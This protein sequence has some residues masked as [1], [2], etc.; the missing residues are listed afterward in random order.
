[1][2]ASDRALL[3]LHVDGGI[4]DESWQLPTP[5]SSGTCSS[6]EELRLKRLR[7]A[8]C[9]LSPPKSPAP[10]PPTAGGYLDDPAG[11]STSPRWCWAARWPVSGGGRLESGPVHGY[12]STRCGRTLHRCPC[13]HFPGWLAAD[14]HPS[15]NDVSTICPQCLY[16]VCKLQCNDIINS[17]T[18]ITAHYCRS[19]LFRTCKT[20]ECT[21]GEQFANFNELY[22]VTHCT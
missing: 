3:I 18:V 15:I 4:S 22:N 21:L 6:D 11:S 13:W 12:M 19:L 16:P 5:I 10:G 14:N 8:S 1:M 2:L 7:T 9:R 20:Y 17:F